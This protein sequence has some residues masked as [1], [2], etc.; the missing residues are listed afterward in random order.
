MRTV[1]RDRTYIAQHWLVLFKPVLRYSSARNAYV[2]RLVGR[3]FGPVVRPE[4]RTKLRM[5]A[6]GIDRRGE[7]TTV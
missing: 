3:K 4:R 7:A 2:L 6:N 5:P 1:R